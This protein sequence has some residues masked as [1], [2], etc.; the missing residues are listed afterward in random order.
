LSEEWE[1]L[2]MELNRELA[3]LSDRLAASGSKDFH[4]ILNCGLELEGWASRAGAL[5]GFWQAE[6]DSR[7]KVLGEGVRAGQALS[8]ATEKLMRLIISASENLNQ[9]AKGREGVLIGGPRT[10]EGKQDGT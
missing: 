8:N 1:L 5:G 3:E 6:I 10:L 4:E 9:F 7:A 2:K